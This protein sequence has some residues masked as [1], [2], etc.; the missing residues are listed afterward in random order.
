ML[1]IAQFIR[2]FRNDEEGQALTE[3]GLIIALIAVALV[4]G[5]MALSGQLDSIFSY[6]TEHLV[7]PTT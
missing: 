7:R 1:Q 5:L 4:V 3:Y 6:V 2:H